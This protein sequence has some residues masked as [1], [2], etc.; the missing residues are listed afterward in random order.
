MPE[1][2]VTIDDPEVFDQLSRRKNDLDL[3]WRDV[4]L[5]G[6]RHE[7]GMDLDAIIERLQAAE[8]A[9]VYFECLSDSYQK[10]IPVRVR[11]VT[12]AEG[13]EVEWV[14]IRHGD[15]ENQNR[16]DS[17]DRDQIAEH[18]AEGGV[19]ILEFDDDNAKYEVRPELAWSRM[20]YGQLTVTDV[21]RLEII[22]RKPE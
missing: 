8:N 19:A 7:N 9:A 10:L 11:L 18:L 21:N 17:D 1:I 16:F 2:R 5:R 14:G 15:T 4:V 20:E 3:S 6:L 12:G 13:Y 22:G